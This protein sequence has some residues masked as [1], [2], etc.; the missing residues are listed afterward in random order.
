MRRSAG[1]AAATLLL[2]GVSQLPQSTFRSSADAVLVHVLVRQGARSV[3]DLACSDFELRDNGV[4]QTLD[5]CSYGELPLDLSVVADV[6]H[7]VAGPVLDRIRASVQTTRRLALPVD[8]VRVISVA[9]AI[10]E[11]A[12]DDGLQ[13]PVGDDRGHTALIDGIAAA[14][15]RP[16]DPGRRRIALVF[17]DGLDSHSI[18]PKELVQGLADRGDTVV[19]VFAIAESRGIWMNMLLGTK[20]PADYFWFLGDLARRTEGTFSDLKPDRDLEPL[21]QAAIADV[22]TRYLL[23][24]VPRDVAPGG[25]HRIEMKINRPGRYQIS[26]RQGYQR[27]R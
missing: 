5:S 26:A 8:R 15:M 20:S 24:Y 7:G 13:I 6:S 23:R 1:A 17:T 4:P 27:S 3:A 18:V 9:S 12:G 19:H 21:L 10:Q 16:A 25:W 11:V 2:S 14:I 22:R